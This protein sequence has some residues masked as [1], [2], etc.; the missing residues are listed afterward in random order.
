MTP[1]LLFTL[2]L[3]AALLCAGGF[4]LWL[5]PWSDADVARTSRAFR[6][7]PKLAN[8]AVARVAPAPRM[9]RRAA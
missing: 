9:E 8:R 6:G 1:D 5:L 2:V 3:S 4:A 7:L